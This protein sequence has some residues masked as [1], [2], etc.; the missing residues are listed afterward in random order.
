MKRSMDQKPL[1]WKGE[2]RCR[3]E[4]FDLGRCVNVREKKWAASLK[5]IEIYIIAAPKDIPVAAAENEK[6]N[7]LSSLKWSSNL[8][9]AFLHVSYRIKSPLN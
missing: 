5:L 7:P 1:I 3:S 9:D 6:S 8:K 2:G 4:T